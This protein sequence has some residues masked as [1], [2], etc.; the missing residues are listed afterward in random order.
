MEI[1]VTT[2]IC[3]AIV[4]ITLIIALCICHKAKYETERMRALMYKEQGHGRDWKELAL[5]L[6]KK[7]QSI[8]ISKFMD[9]IADKVGT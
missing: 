6:L 2:I 4:L 7:H 1:A 8:D 9:K 3:T 5:V